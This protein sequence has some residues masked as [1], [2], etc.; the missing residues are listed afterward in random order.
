MPRG[1]R[2]RRRGPQRRRTRGTRAPTPS[3]GLPGAEEMAT[4]KAADETR[5]Q[6]D[7]VRAFRDAEREPRERG[8]GG[9]RERREALF[10]PPA[11]ATPEP[12]VSQRAPP[13]FQPPPAAT[14][15]PGEFGAGGLPGGV[16]VFNPM[17]LPP[18][19]PWRERYLLD[20]RNLYLQG[21]AGR[22]ALRLPRAARPA[23]GPY[24]WTQGGQYVMPRTWQSD[25]GAPEYRVPW[26]VPPGLSPESPFTPG[27]Y[28]QG[29]QQLTF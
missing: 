19:H 2:R 8:D 18:G 6:Q 17:D 20:Q 25:A 10:Q 4:W 22:L 12:S 24:D 13:P 29:R 3:S 15:A 23:P 26:V 28:M 9:G 16:G 14:P 21:L 1:V 27:P 11:A 7:A 5:Q